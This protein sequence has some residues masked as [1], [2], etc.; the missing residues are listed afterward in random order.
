MSY[1]ILAHRGWSGVAP[2]NTLSAFKLALN[3]PTVDAIECDIQ[4]TKDGQIVVVHDFTLGRTSNGT[5]LIKEYTL[6]QLRQLDFGGWFSDQFRGERISTFSELL[7]LIAGKKRLVVE[8]KTTANLYPQLADKL[9]EEIADYPQE[10]LM[11][12]SFDHG[13]VK[14]IKDRNPELCTG[15]ILHDHVTLLMEQIK[16]TNSN[17]ISLFFGNLSQS[18]ADTLAAEKVETILWTLN[19]PW[20]YEYIKQFNG[21]FYLASDHPGLAAQQMEL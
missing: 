7:A 19:Q 13:L 2:E 5:G 1:R 17:F 20:Q 21:T 18:L 14:Q 12:E 3:D 4:L 8:L 15:L 11:I 10:T 9:L 6:A 16:Y